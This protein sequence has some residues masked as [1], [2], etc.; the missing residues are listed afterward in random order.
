MFGK[1]KDKLKSLFSKN[2]EI[3]EEKG[4]EIVETPIIE[5]KIIKSS[6]LF[7]PISLGSFRQKIPKKKFFGV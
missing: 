5:D 7:S 1:I 2:E 4:E 3:I 6:S